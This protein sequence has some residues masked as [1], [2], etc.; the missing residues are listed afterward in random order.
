LSDFEADIELL[1]S[2]L[3]ALYSKGSIENKDAVMI[4]VRRN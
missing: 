4:S 3:E 1:A 2:N